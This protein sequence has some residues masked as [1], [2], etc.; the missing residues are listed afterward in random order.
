MLAFA[1]VGLLANAIS[2][3]VLAAGGAPRSTCAGAY[4]EVL[5]DTVGSVA[6]WRPRW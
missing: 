5:S 4:L 1:V 2:L 6:A 3:V